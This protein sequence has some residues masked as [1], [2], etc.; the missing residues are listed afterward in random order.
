MLNKP[1]KTAAE[2]SLGH[3]VVA[4]CEIAERNIQIEAVNV[5]SL[6]R[7]MFWV[8]LKSMRLDGISS[9]IT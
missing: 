3:R 6:V 7:A 8:E 5:Q 2:V 4:L 1:F 9:A